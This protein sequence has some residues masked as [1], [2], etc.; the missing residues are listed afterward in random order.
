MTP[1]LL[2]VLFVVGLFAVALAFGLYRAYTF[3]AASRSR[4]GLVPQA[5]SRGRFLGRGGVAVTPLRPTGIVVVHGSRLE[6]TTEGEFIAAGS[7]VRI[8]AMSRDQYIV[9]LDPDG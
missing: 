9:R 6:A 5:S 8:V 7:R 4:G 3:R 1:L 2:L